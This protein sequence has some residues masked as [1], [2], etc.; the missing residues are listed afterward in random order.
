MRAFLG[1][2][3]CFW[4]KKRVK[5]GVCSYSFVNITKMQAVDSVFVTSNEEAK[6][7][8]PQGGGVGVRRFLGRRNGEDRD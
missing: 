5:N 1:K 3:A 2:M 4:A 6:K 8:F 7:R